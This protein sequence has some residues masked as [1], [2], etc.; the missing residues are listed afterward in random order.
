MNIERMVRRVAGTV[1]IL[2]VILAHYYSP[3]WLLLTLFVGANL[4]QSS[5]TGFCPL[6]LILAKFGLKPACEAPSNKAG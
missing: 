6:A 3:L 4:F 1:I 5:F 2:S